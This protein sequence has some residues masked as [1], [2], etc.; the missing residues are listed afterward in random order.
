MTENERPP[1]PP[2]GAAEAAKARRVAT[3]LRR[4]VP[5]FVLFGLLRVWHVWH[6]HGHTQAIV[7]LAC[8]LVVLFGLGGLVPWFLERTVER[9]GVADE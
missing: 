2:M 6:S 7:L 8:L 1:A 5:L 4:V 3:I 9:R